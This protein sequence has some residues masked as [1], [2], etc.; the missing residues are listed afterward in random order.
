MRSSRKVVALGLTGLLTGALALGA[1]PGPDVTLAPAPDAAALGAEALHLAIDGTTTHLLA[2]RL[3][4]WPGRARGDGEAAIAQLRQQARDAYDRARSLLDATRDQAG[5]DLVAR[6]VFEGSAAYIA[7]MWDLARR[8][9][10]YDQPA[11][12]TRAA[13]ALT[14]ADV[15]AIEAINRAVAEA[16]D[17]F[18]LRQLASRMV[19]TT[20]PAARQL[21]ATA[22]AMAR[23]GAR[24]AGRFPTIPRADRDRYQAEIDA[25]DARLDWVKQQEKDAKD[26]EKDVKFH[27]T[28]GDQFKAEAGEAQL[29]AVRAFLKDANAAAK[30]FKATAQKGKDQAADARDAE[31]RPDAGPDLAELAR[32]GHALIQLLRNLTVV[33]DADAKG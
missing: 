16:A 24:A 33:P 15:A 14:L 20:G 2:R 25:A 31:I 9:T 5:A 1:S 29:K 10:P 28:F 7:V 13:G 6:Q 26:F 32:L 11:G 30:S 17:A 8:A 19:P 3:E 27:K 12:K 18:L 23:S 21:A 4:T 22:E